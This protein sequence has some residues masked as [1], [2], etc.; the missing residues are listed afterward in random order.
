MDIYIKFKKIVFHIRV[1]RQILNSDEEAFWN[2]CDWKSLSLLV[3]VRRIKQAFQK[4]FKKSKQ[5]LHSSKIPTDVSDINLFA[6]CQ[7][8]S[9]WWRKIYRNLSKLCN[10]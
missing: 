6:L 9:D 8:F 4:P 7:Q 10:R 2:I 3:E 5:I 1:I